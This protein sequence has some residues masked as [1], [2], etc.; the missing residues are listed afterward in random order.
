MITLSRITRYRREVNSASKEAGNYV[1]AVL[2]VY[3]SQYPN[4]S[5]AEVRNLMSETIREAVNLYGDSASTLSNELFDEIAEDNKESYPTEIYN[6]IDPNKVDE[7]VRYFANSLVKGDIADFAHSVRDITQYYVKRCAFDNMLKNCKKNK[8]RYARVPSGFETCAFCFMLA[9]RGFVYHTESD[10]GGSGHSYHQHCDC[11]IVPGFHESEMDPDSQI[12]GYKPNELYDRYKDC[13]RAVTDPDGS[14]SYQLFKNNYV[15]TG[16]YKD[17]PKDW[18]RWKRNQLV[19]EIRTRDF[20]WLWTGISPSVE[21]TTENVQKRVTSTE[22]NTARI[23]SN[24]GI[25]CVFKQDYKGV[26][27]NGRNLRLGLA[28]MEGGIE[29]KAIIKSKNA[30]GAV[31]NHLESSNGKQDLKKVVFDLSETEY[32]EEKDIIAQIQAQVKDFSN[33]T[34]VYVITKDE[35]LFKVT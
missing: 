9:S 16:K 20:N 2:D 34:D 18:E 29:L 31:Q 3:R 35:K 6:N 12:E 24:H 33:V 14:W 11:I 1:Q 13:K 17:T 25:K 27:L 26:R 22:I 7:K 4:A 21:Y 8:L 23:L 30:K 19:K 10:A 32:L 15:A 5:L 28:D